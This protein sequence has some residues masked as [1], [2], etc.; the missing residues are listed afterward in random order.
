[1]LPFGRTA[2]DILSLIYRVNSSQKDLDKQVE[3]AVE[4]LTTSTNLISQLEDSLE[5][6]AAKLNELQSEYERISNLAKLTEEQ[7]EAVAKTLE[8]TLGKGQVRERWIAF[9]INV[10]AGLIIFVLGVFASDWVKE[11]PNLIQDQ[12]AVEA[13]FEDDQKI[14]Q[15]E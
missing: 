11:L 1:M 10:V 7:G 12:F 9:A 15:T 4:A 2:D 6:R 8:Q 3:E 5:A 14:P 13:P